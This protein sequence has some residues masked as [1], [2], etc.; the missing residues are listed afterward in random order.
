MSSYQHRRPE[1]RRD[2]LG[3]R[4]VE[5]D[6]R[7]GRVE[8]LELAPALRLPGAEQTIR[9]R[10]ARTAELP[11]GMVAAV[12]RID[13]TAAGLAVVSAAVGGVLL[14]DL[15]AAFDA[16]E[17]TVNDSLLFELAATVIR[18][19]ASLHELPGAFAHG[20]ISPWHIALL[21]SGVV[22]FTDA[23]FATLLQ[24]LHC[25]REQLWKEYG[26]AFPSAASLPRFDQRADT[27]QLGAAVLAILLRRPLAA[28]E[29]PRRVLD[30]AL[31]A[32]AAPA[33]YASAMRMWIQQALQLHPR[34]VFTSAAD[35]GR[36][37]EE[38]TQHVTGRRTAA[39][40]LQ[41]LL[42]EMAGGTD[43][44]SPVAPEHAVVAR[45][46]QLRVLRPVLPNLRAT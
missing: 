39:E 34:S 46:S 35:A 15:L 36:A 28:D 7:H 18:G 33:P 4:R 1:D 10:A 24:D 45:G 44:A 2:G 37:F 38:M 11:G 3:A 8:I 12:Y 23:P 20:A 32:T 22:T 14:G 13:R 5:N 31:D 9:S 27:T 6:A 30:L 17:I 41:R 26:L 16:G 40:A 19:V 29:Y 43:D 42:R 21:P 25:N